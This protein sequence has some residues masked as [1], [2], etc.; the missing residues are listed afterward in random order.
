MLWELPWDLSTQN[1]GHGT[2]RTRASQV[3]PQSSVAQACWVQRA[4]H[5]PQA[6]VS[7]EPDWQGALAFSISPSRKVPIPPTQAEFQKNCSFQRKSSLVPMTGPGLPPAVCAGEEGCGHLERWTRPWLLLGTHK[8][9]SWVSAL[10]Q[11]GKNEDPA[12]CG[13][14]GPDPHPPPNTQSTI[15]KLA[16]CLAGSLLHNGLFLLE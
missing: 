11:A 13:H 14:R 1:R 12:S 7:S 3:G 5:I 16:Q 15:L 6:P 8:A 10:G 2:P 4:P 9:Q